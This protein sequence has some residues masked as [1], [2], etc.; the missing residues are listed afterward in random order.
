MPL[1]GT[2]EHRYLKRP[3]IHATI[4]ALL[5]PAATPHRLI[6]EPE[7]LYPGL[8]FVSHGGKCTRG[9]TGGNRPAGLSSQAIHS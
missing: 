4:T 7:A 2:W 5:S 6:E 3:F 8:M 1:W 9:R